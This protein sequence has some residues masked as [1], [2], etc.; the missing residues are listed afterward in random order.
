MRKHSYVSLYTKS[1]EEF[2]DKAIKI[3]EKNSEETVIIL[4]GMEVVTNISRMTEQYQTIQE[5]SKTSIILCT[6]LENR[7]I[8]YQSPELLQEI[9]TRAQ[10]LFFGEKTDFKLAEIPFG[11]MKQCRDRKNK[12]KF[13][14]GMVLIWRNGR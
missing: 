7:T 4:N 14:I 2:F 6:N 13:S 9:K 1:G 8:R 5:I 10:I 11:E 3:I 12:S